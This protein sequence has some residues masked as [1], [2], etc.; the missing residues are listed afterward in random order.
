M[1]AG[2]SGEYPTPA[3]FNDQ[4]LGEA[5]TYVYIAYIAHASPGAPV[6]VEK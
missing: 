1:G 5:R 4:P 2:Q 3:T 6:E